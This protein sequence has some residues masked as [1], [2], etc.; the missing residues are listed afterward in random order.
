MHDEHFVSF[1]LVSE[2]W[3]TSSKDSRR[4]LAFFAKNFAPDSAD[5]GFRWIQDTNPRIH[6]WGVLKRG[7]PPTLLHH[8]VSILKVKT[9][10][11]WDRRYQCSDQPIPAYVRDKPWAMVGEDMIQGRF[12]SLWFEK[13]DE[14]SLRMQS[15]PVE[16]PD[17]RGLWPV[18][19][20]S[21]KPWLLIVSTGSCQ[22]STGSLAADAMHQDTMF[23]QS[24]QSQISLDR[25]VPHGQNL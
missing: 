8:I 21:V 15:S 10:I 16:H 5:L 19:A 18:T 7:I 3:P 11:Y 25:H 4:L 20:R 6:T 23:S 14:S 9:R 2:A 17:T 22:G 13:L 12:V 24:L 1:C